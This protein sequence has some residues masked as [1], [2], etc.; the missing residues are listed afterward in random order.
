MSEHTIKIEK[1][2]AKSTDQDVII[3]SQKQEINVC[4]QTEDTHT[5]QI[6]DL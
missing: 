2:V 4:K 3:A 5:Q 6:A 1:L